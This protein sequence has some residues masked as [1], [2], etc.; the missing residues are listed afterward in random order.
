[1]DFKNISVN[2]P[3]SSELNEPQE[4]PAAPERQ[5]IPGGVSDIKDL[6]EPLGSQNPTGE[7]FDSSNFQDASVSRLS[8]KAGEIESPT[9]AIWGSDQMSFEAAQE[10]ISELEGM[11]QG[12]DTP[13]AKALLQQLQDLESKCNDKYAQ[14]ATGPSQDQ[15]KELRRLEEQ[16]EA[17]AH[18]ITVAEEN[19]G[20]QPAADAQPISDVAS[21]PAEDPAA[22]DPNQPDPNLAADAAGADPAQNIDAPPDPN[23]P[24]A[25]ADPDPNL[26][27]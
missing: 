1:V 22:V 4:Q 5:P 3:I 26:D 12:I 18:Q 16:V 17:L 13:E 6:I 9:D 20:A 7:F 2:R 27:A 21:P 25:Q 11:L 14:F 15:M 19:P 24:N 23:D 8:I 10:E